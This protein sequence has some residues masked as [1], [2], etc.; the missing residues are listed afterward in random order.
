MEKGTTC[1]KDGY[2]DQLDHIRNIYD[3]LETFLTQAAHQILEIVPLLQVCRMI[4]NNRIIRNN[5]V[6]CNHRI[7]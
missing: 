3:T 1:I 4:C 6:I 7:I 5:K 2:D